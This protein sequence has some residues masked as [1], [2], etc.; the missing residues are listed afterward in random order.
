MRI[1]LDKVLLFFLVKRKNSRK[2]Q[3][4]LQL[5]RAQKMKNI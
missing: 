3:L 1:K 4:M 5:V 2:A